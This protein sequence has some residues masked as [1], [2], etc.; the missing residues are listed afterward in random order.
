M[1]ANDH[2]VERHEARTGRRP[3]LATVHGDGRPD[4]PWTKLVEVHPPTGV[5]GLLP[6]LV[7]LRL[8]ARGR[9]AVVL[10]GTTGASEGW[11]DLLAAAVLRLT[12]CRARVVVSDSTLEP[13]SAS[14]AARLPPQAAVLLEHISVGL[15]RVAD[16]SRTTWCVLSTDEQRAFRSTWGVRRGHVVHTPFCHSVHE[17]E[18]VRPASGRFV[19]AG[20]NSLRDYERLVGEWA[21]D[22]PPLRV[23]T[24]R[25]VRTAAP[26]GAVVDV[27]PCSPHEF[28]DLMAGA[29][30]VCLP[31]L[32]ARR[33]TGQ[34]T[35][36]NAMRLRRPLV[37]SD[38]P[39]VRDHVED[40]VTGFVADDAP[41]GLAAAVRRALATD[42]GAMEII[43]DRAA[44]AVDGEWTPMRYRRRL[45]EVAGVLPA[46][47]GADQGP[48]AAR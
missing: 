37:V 39:G 25:P 29:E 1:R 17:P 32:R 13:G 21:S 18:R 42:V 24:T 27:R 48:P 4:D 34:Q 19:F 20:G 2:D 44:A 12:G 22:L 47:G 35:Y 33:S 31:L 46:R 28:L 7:R 23:A 26:A 16:S 9:Q 15:V 14:L 41:G 30:V 11:S 8:A 36:L 5:A 45:L 10:R 43:L 40:G 38:A 6:W 3:V